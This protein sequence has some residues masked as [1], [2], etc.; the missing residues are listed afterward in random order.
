MLQPGADSATCRE[1]E[2]E[3]FWGGD[4]GQGEVEDSA[5]SQGWPGDG[6]KAGVGVS[7]C[8]AEG[9]AVA[10]CGEEEGAEGEL[11]GVEID[12]SKAS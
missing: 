10:A 8:S 3:T 1:D 12:E 7:E 9:F 2:S 11:Q 6:D 5:G 4:P